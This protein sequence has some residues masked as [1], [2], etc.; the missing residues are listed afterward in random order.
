MGGSHLASP[1]LGSPFR[2][3]FSGTCL[4][5]VR[6]SNDRKAK[7]STARAGSPGDV[8][9]VSWF[10]HFPEIFSLGKPAW[11]AS[12][13]E[14]AWEDAA[15][16]HHCQFNKQAD[17][18]CFRKRQPAKKKNCFFITHREIR[19]PFLLEPRSY[20]MLLLWC[21]HVGVLQHSGQSSN[22]CCVS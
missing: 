8:K 21:I 12:V 19:F 4:P 17:R 9:L 1:A 20:H 11:S 7:H 15:V 16:S 10:F 18:Q 6:R 22:F 5:F 13:S 2:R 14:R 3:F